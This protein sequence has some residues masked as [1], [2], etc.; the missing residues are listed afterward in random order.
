MENS[1]NFRTIKIS[2]EEIETIKMALQYVYDKK[3]DIV[4]TNRKV[5]SE[6]ASNAILKQANKY[7]DTQDVFN[8]DR[9]V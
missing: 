9:D 2:H 4:A 7:F 8:G 5:L 1:A 3:M 6:E